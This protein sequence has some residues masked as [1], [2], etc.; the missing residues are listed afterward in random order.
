VG[1]HLVESLRNTPATN[2]IVR[3]AVLLHDIGKPKTYAKTDEGVTTFYNHEIIGTTMVR[4]IAGRLHLS[5]KDT[6]LLIRLV[7]WHQF[8][9]DD[10]QTDSALRRFI[11]NV[12]RENLKDILDLRTGDRLGSG[13]KETSWRLEL[14]KKRL[15]EVERQPFSVTDLKIN[16]NDVMKTLNLKPGPQVG[17]ILIE[18]FNQ[19]VEGQVKNEKDELLEKIQKMN[20]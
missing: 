12:G 16:G 11:R 13:S 19:V 18:L 14:F 20:H 5:K 17:K 1:T 15:D 9:V 8:S 7:R 3:L 6:G 2:H 10:K 4:D